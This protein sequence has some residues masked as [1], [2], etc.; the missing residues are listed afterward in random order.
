MP[1]LLDWKSSDWVQRSVYHT[2]LENPPA[3]LSSIKPP[4]VADWPAVMKQRKAFAD[5]HID[6]STL[7]D[8][9]L[10]SHRRRCAP[11][12][13]LENIEALRSADAFLVIA[14]QQPGLLGG[15]LLTLYKAMQAIVEAR[16]LTQNTAYHF[17]PAFWNAS[18]DHD[19]SE[20]DA[21]T[22]VDAQGE[23]ITH[24]WQGKPSSAPYYELPAQSIPVNEIAEQLGA[25]YPEMAE[26][27]KLAQ[28]IPAMVAQAHSL[29]DAFD[30]LLWRWLGQSGLLI[31]RPEDDAVRLAA[32]SILAR[33]LE[34]PL[35]SNR[36][37]AQAGHILQE[38]GAQ[39]Q[40]Q[41]R[42]DRAAFFDLNGQQRRALYW[43][44]GQ[45]VDDNGATLSPSEMRTRLENAP[46]RFSPSAV[47]RPVV[48]EAVLPTAASIVGPSE[49][50]Y[51][52]LL[53]GIYRQ[54]ETPRP[55]LIPRSGM[56]LLE[57]RDVRHLEKLGLSMHDLRHDRAALMKRWVQRNHPV[58]MDAAL[59]AMAQTF[60]HM[61]ARLAQTDPTG[62]PP[63]DSN[64]KRIE[65]W[66]HDSEHLTLR[67]EARRHGEIEAQIKR[68]QHSLLPGGRLQERVLCPLQFWARHGDA[69]FSTLLDL[70]Q[71]IP[72]GEHVF[73]RLP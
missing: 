67:R 72:N 15:P 71:Q 9:L 58:S 44:S 17:I 53:D 31:I 32:R 4:S 38:H 26:A 28:E 23:Q 10:Q 19:L 33:E 16:R 57:S 62:I 2:W 11:S 52:F 35:Q 55:A 1:Q 3:G 22:W 64:Q 61:R 13:V 5:E 68:L 56:T 42:E 65:K 73:V 45:F 27:A 43:R 50:A 69:F 47:L 36:S 63:L 7:T 8:R 30:A 37:V 24:R 39:P 49:L 40:I 66:L 54:H 34:A 70:M 46:H 41:Q 6:R 14:G 29:A 48:Q 12:P 18:E 25:Q 20:V 60:D 21:A 51:H 59:Q